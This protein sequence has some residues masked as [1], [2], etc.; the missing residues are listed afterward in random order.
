MKITRI[1]HFVLT[2]RNM[3][4]TI[5]FYTQILG[6]ELVTFEKDRKALKFG[7]QKFNLH[8]YQNT[9]N[10]TLVAET[11]LPGSEDFCLITE[12]PITE[13]VAHLKEHGVEIISG[14][15]IRTGAIGPLN[16]IYFRDPDGNLVEVSNY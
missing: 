6:M 13:V 10:P 11:P 7:Q 4:A 16:S 2:V 9:T 8:Q 14:P 3:K 15:I 12:T 5:E 1:D